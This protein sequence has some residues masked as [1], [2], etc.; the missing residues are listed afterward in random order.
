MADDE[1]FGAA[2]DDDIFEAEKVRNPIAPLQVQKASYTAKHEDHGWFHNE[3]S[4]AHL[5]T[6]RH[7]PN[8]IKLT[9][10]HDYLYKRY[11]RAL[12]TSLE[13]IA[14]VE[15]DSIDCKVVNPR[16]I[17]ETAALCAMKLDDIETAM[18][19]ADKMNSRELGS[20]QTR[21][22]VYMHGA[23]YS[24]AISCFIQYNN[25]RALDYKPWRHMA[26]T[27][28]KS[29]NDEPS[30]DNKLRLHLADA[31]LDRSL[32][33]LTSGVWPNVDFARARYQREYDDLKE[34]DS[35]IKELG[36]SA[37]VFFAVMSAT[38]ESVPSCLQLFQWDDIVWIDAE[39]RRVAGNKDIEDEHTKSVREL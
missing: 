25:M 17:I 1:L 5:M 18:Q 35:Q 4:I 22:V 32:T 15:D 2:F 8:Q 33:I 16:E 38:G 28:L 37:S 34:L 13:Y 24:D 39:C 9:I 6:T 3:D 19:C 23:R 27:F 20:L 10:E 36:G 14:A 29:Y 7:G 30:E 31:S 26:T 11:A 12:K 21:G